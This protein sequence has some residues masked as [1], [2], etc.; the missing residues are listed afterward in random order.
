MAE[1]DSIARLAARLHRQTAGSVV[2]TCDVRHPRF[3]LVDLTGQQIE[4]WCPRGKHLLMR[5]DAGVTVHSHLRMSGTWSVLGEGRRLPPA[6]AATRRISLGLHDG[7]TLVG[8][9]LPVLTVLATRDEHRVVGH[10]G[11]DLLS[12]TVDPGAELATAAANLRAAG[13]TPMVAALLDQRRVAGLGNMWAQELLF[14]HGLDPWQPAAGVDAAP[15]LVDARARLR[16]AVERN[17]RQNTT[18]RRF[19]AHWVYGRAR[20]PCLRCGTPIAFRDAARTPHGR[21][22]W[23]CP[24][25]QPAAGSSTVPERTAPQ[26][27][28]QDEPLRRRR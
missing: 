17:P 16:D 15:L 27:R 28:D 20:R 23:W 1:G 2:R 5:T 13:A 21:E 6:V 12:G 24:T 10:L 22:T 4:E 26:G 7:R 11:P 3:A 14:L 9:A 25:C 8:I 18:G 19:P